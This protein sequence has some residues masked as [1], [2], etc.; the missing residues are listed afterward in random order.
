MGVTKEPGGPEK[1]VGQEKRERGK[2]GQ[3][4]IRDVG[5]SRVENRDSI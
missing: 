5:R 1:P 2:V 3:G 4:E